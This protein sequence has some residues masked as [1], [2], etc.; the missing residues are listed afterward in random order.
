MPIYPR[1]E[2]SLNPTWSRAE[3]KK[4]VKEIHSF[5]SLQIL[6]LLYSVWTEKICVLQIIGAFSSCELLIFCLT[7]FAIYAS[8]DM[9]SQRT[10]HTHAFDSSITYSSLALFSWR[11][12]SPSTT[13]GHRHCHRPLHC[14]LHDQVLHEHFEVH[15]VVCACLIAAVEPAPLAREAN[16]KNQYQNG[17]SIQRYIHH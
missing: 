10:Q 12:E 11:E 14:A 8:C 13:A 3:S 16:E 6:N 2:W 4:I 7:S 5:S 1:I 15:S 17:Q 9:Q